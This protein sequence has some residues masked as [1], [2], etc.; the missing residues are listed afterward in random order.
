MTVPATADAHV[1]LHSEDGAHRGERADRAVDPVIKVE[2]LAW[3]EF[4][5]PD[6]D[7]AERFA[8]DFGFSVAL[9]TGRE[10]HLRGSWAGSVCVVIRKA[11]QSR[12]IGPVF[13]AADAVDLDRLARA[14]DTL[15]RTNAEMG[16]REVLLRNPDG[17]PVRV[18]ADVPQLSGLPD[19]EA[20]TWNQGSQLSRINRVQRPAREPA[21]VQRLGHVVV[22]TPRFVAN[23]E[24]Y[25]R[26][27]GLIVSDYL[28]FPGQRERGP[29]MAFIRCDR[30]ST[31]ADH[32][33]LAL[34]LGPQSRYVHSA[35]Q[36]ADLD[37]VA[38]GGAYLAEQGH[39]HAWG[40]GRHIQGSQI[41]DYWR[42]PDHLMVEHFADSDKFDNT[43]PAGWAQMGASG[44]SQWGPSVT[45]DFL[46]ARP[47]PQLIR[48]VV[49]ALREPENEFD[50]NRFLGLLKV[51]RS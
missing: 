33:T 3:I 20:L 13:R 29:T 1:G 38:A 42:D 46:D 5:K 32:H 37:A 39:H 31:P 27:L 18:V 17:G 44:L 12:Y 7:R 21:R 10:L 30:G 43:V 15:V 14:H 34:T 36:V 9:R 22:E 2:D 49:Q 40:I 25:L 16:C 8:R 48:A 11:A 35:Y 23:L 24:W 50:V 47:T 41:F 26:N 28:Y 51:A 19:Q 6:L 45:L 4:E